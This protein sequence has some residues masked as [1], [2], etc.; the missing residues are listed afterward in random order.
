MITD[1]IMPG[2][3]NGVELARRMRAQRPG[4]KIIYSSGF[5][6]D[7]LAQKSGTRID[8]PLLYKPYQ[9]SAFVAAVSRVMDAKAPESDG[10]AEAPASDEKAIR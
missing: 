10:S 5:P 7:A 8:A 2:G 9:R 6:S 3:I 1:V 4:L